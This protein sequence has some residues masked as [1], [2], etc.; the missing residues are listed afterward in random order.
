MV[1]E[2]LIAEC[3]TFRYL[4][5]QPKYLSFWIS[6]ANFDAHHLDGALPNSAVGL[7]PNKAHAQ[8]L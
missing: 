5:L 7:S 3:V 6:K 4:M 2:K 8:V 1:L